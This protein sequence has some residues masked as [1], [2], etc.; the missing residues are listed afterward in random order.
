MS[1]QL[2][3]Y[4][5]CNF[6]RQR[7]VLATLSSKAIR[8]T[9][10]RQDSDEPGLKE[11][12]AG[13][14]RLLD[15]ITNGSR[16][17]VNE[18]GTE[19][20][21]E[22][23]LLVG[24]TVEHVCSQQ[25]SIGYFLEP[26]FMLA[27]FAKKP[28]RITLKGITN[29]PCDPSVDYY[30]VCVLPLLK[31]FL[32]DNELELKIRRRGMWPTGSGEVYFSCPVVKKMKAMVMLEEG[33]VR[34]VRGIAYC[35]RVNP[36]MAN[37]MVDSARSVLNNYLPDV[38]IYT[39]AI[40]GA[41][42]G[43]CPGFGLTLVSESTT[44]VTHGAENS[45]VLRRVGPSGQE[46]PTEEGKPANPV[47]PEDV[48]RQAALMLVEEIVKGGCADSGSQ[49]IPLLFLALGQQDVS[50]VK[51]GQLSPY[52]IQFLRHLRDFFQVTYKIDCQQEEMEDI[53]RQVVTLT[54]VGTGF[55]NFSKGMT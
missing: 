41:D 40:K 51:L 54:C 18:T 2:L 15:T 13:F 53:T 42:A 16:I 28:I 47:L 30:R 50:K 26:L 35:M 29:G 4:E 34:R 3:T 39:D 33:K 6:F 17:E 25:R 23:G 32:P 27:P 22:P 37:R 20:F 38:Y 11:F 9:N 44:G 14:I 8:I 19:L 36:G 21:F 43:K 52:T 10:I 49:V 7:L 1:S 31:K 46:V 45:S 5:G 24:G 55:S 12:E 48:G